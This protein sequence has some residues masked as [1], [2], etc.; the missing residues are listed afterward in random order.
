MRGVWT[1]TVSA[2]C[3]MGS[4]VCMP[5]WLC[6]SPRL[7]VGAWMAMSIAEIDCGSLDGYVDRRD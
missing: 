6:R 3:V 2:Q 1:S 4:T 7:T 5:G